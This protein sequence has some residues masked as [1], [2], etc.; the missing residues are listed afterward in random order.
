[1]LGGQSVAPQKTQTDA[2]KRSSGQVPH[3]VATKTT[4]HAVHKR[5]KKAV[6]RRGAKRPVYRPEYSE[7]SVEVINGDATKKVVFQNDQ[8]ANTPRKKLPAGLKNVPAPMKV[9]VVNGGQTDT[10]YF[11][12]N[13]QDKQLEA[14][15]NQPVVIGIQSSDTR[16]V[17]GNKHPVVTGVT[18]SGTGSAKSAS[19]GGQP[20]T[21]QISPR[22]KRPAYQPDAN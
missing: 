15:R 7:N 2:A 11:Y 6:A 12:D 8:V 18:A 1:M 5:H 4:H 19:G 3:T 10:Q 9:E 20:V 17:G 13:G 21:K 22:P 16:V 14:A